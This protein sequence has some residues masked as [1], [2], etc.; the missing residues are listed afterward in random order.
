[1][2]Y[3]GIHFWR[4]NFFLRSLC[5]VHTCVPYCDIIGL[6]Q[7]TNLEEEINQNLRYSSTFKCINS[8]SKKGEKIC[9]TWIY[10]EKNFFN[11]THCYGWS[12][13]RFKSITFLPIID[14]KIRQMEVSLCVVVQSMTKR[15]PKRN[16]YEFEKEL[17]ICQGL[18]IN[19]DAPLWYRF[20]II[21][22]IRVSRK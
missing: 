3:K 18:C 13:F 2:S 17:P 8:S 4:P 20:Q 16:I 21:L 15:F 11:I 9:G 10:S 6:V 19:N 7:N 22:K 5:L 12:V 14:F 1:M